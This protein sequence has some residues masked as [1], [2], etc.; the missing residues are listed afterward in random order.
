MT[1]LDEMARAIEAH[2]I[3][4]ANIN[5]NDEDS[6]HDV[7]LCVIQQTYRDLRKL[8]LEIRGLK[9]ELETCHR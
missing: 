5:N 4:Y 8:K 7:L 2:E 1:L 3:A 9:D 6:R